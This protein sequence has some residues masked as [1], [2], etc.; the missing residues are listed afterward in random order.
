MTG[1]FMK[2]KNIKGWLKG[3]VMVNVCIIILYVCTL[4]LKIYIRVDKHFQSD[5]FLWVHVSLVYLSRI[6]YIL[7]FI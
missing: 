4:K 3:N 5:E 7:Y 2:N 6:S 1:I